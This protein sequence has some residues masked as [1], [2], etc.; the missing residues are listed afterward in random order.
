MLYQGGLGRV[1][2]STL[3]TTKMKELITFDLYRAP[4]PVQI[5][6]VDV[7]VVGNYWYLELVLDNKLDW[8][9]NTHHLSIKGQSRLYFLMRLLLWTFS[10]LVCLHKVSV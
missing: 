4:R 5:E 9:N 2:V 7:V 6:G 10:L 8:I 3:N 1:K